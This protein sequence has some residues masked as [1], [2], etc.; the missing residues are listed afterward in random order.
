M[1]N[2]P[3]FIIS[4]IDTHRQTIDKFKGERYNQIK[5]LS[6]RYVIYRSD[7]LKSILVSY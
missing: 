2:K 3:L 1:F 4:G 6:P 7:F 5:S